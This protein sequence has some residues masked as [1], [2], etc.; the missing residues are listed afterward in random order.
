MEAR[1]T[2]PE[3]EK[4]KK[5]RR[6]KEK[7]EEKKEKKKEKKARK[8]KQYE[9][10]LLEPFRDIFEGGG[11]PSDEPQTPPLRTRPTEVRD[12]ASAPAELPPPT[13][14]SGQVAPPTSSTTTGIIRGISPVAAGAARAIPRTELSAQAKL[15]V[16]WPKRPMEAEQQSPSSSSTTARPKGDT[17]KVQKDQ[18]PTSTATS[19][20]HDSQQLLD[21][22]QP[23]TAPAWCE[24][25]PENTHLTQAKEEVDG[26]APIQ[27]KLYQQWDQPSYNER[28]LHPDVDVFDDGVDSGTKG[29][30]KYPTTEGGNTNY[31][32]TTKDDIEHDL[33]VEESGQACMKGKRAPKGEYPD[34]EGNSDDEDVDPLE[35]KGGNPSS[36]SQRPP[37]PGGE[38]PRLNLGQKRRLQQLL[39]DGML[40]RGNPAETD[41]EMWKRYRSESKQEYRKHRREERRQGRWQ[42]KPRR[43]SR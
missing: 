37:E 32:P 35:E 38:P 8:D 25:P 10:A 28:R 40:Q 43:S 24:P 11:T 5:D 20:T 6:K 31:D 26:D 13:A 16:Q 14:L 12:M 4:N 1:G 41:E 36:S 18:E 27:A 23:E 29:D 34:D 17:P 3:R 30:M 2:T 9:E 39:Q 42:E 7:K 22:E 33:T 21:R 15:Q 19:P